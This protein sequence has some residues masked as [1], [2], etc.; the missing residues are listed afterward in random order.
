LRTIVGESSDHI[1]RMIAPD[2]DIDS[3][4]RTCLPLATALDFGMRSWNTKVIRPAV[5]QLPN[6]C[7]AREV[8]PGPTVE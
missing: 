3:L 4:E 5:W 6:F 8:R 1:R 7:V 2:D